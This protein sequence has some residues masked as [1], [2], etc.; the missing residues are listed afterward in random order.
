M[1]Y[2]VSGYGSVGLREL[3]CELILKVIISGTG[4][5]VKTRVRRTQLAFEWALFYFKT[6]KRDIYYY[7]CNFIQCTEHMFKK[8]IPTNQPTKWLPPKQ[9]HPCPPQNYLNICK[10]GHFTGDGHIDWVW[11]SHPAHICNVW[12]PSISE[13]EASI[14]WALTEAT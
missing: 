14:S 2:R 3:Q 11:S 5:W 4:G 12:V 8:K 6:R 7:K 1:E 9:K 10:W 13:V